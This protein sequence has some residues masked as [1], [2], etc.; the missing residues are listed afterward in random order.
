MWECVARCLFLCVILATATVVPLLQVTYAFTTL[1]FI[2]TTNVS[3]QKLIYTSYRHFL[4]SEASLL[5]IALTQ[6][7]LSYY[8]KSGY[9]GNEYFANAI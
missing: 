4:V 3:L 6:G 8:V 5:T 9:S 7:F 1:V 2:C